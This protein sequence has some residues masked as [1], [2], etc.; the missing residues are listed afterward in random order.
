MY[1]SR[2]DMVRDWLEMYRREE[3]ELDE[4]I[5]RIRELR[6][7]VTGAKAQELSFTPKAHNVGDMMTEYM[8]RL[9]ALEGDMERRLAAHE[10]DREAIVNLI[11]KL[12]RDEDRDVIKYKYLYG[13]EWREIKPKLYEKE[14]GYKEKP[15][16]FERRMYRA[17][18]RALEWMGRLWDKR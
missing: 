10:R 8:I 18:I 2:A 1:K 15:E 4:L 12:K 17:H 5:N 7:S 13:M 16:T 14:E 9:E 11:S 6:S 3:G